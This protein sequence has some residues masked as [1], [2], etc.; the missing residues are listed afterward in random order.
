MSQD[1]KLISRMVRRVKNVVRPWIRGNPNYFLRKASG[2]IH[3]GAN[4]GQ[5]RNLYGKHN[6]DVI[7][8]E[9]IPDVYMSLKQNLEGFPRQHAFQRLITDRDDAE[10]TFHISNNDGKSSSIFD[11]DLHKEIWPTVSFQESIRLKGMT[12]ASFAQK[13][14]IDMNR[15]DA[16]VLD[17]QGS[18]LLVLKGASTLFTYFKYIK[19]EAADFESYAGCCKVEDIDSLLKQ[20]GYVKRRQDKFASKAGVGSYYDVLYK[21][22]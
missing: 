21:Q 11:L 12:L 20:F 5:E 9:P 22:T 18:E 4:S 6:L 1:S 3:V 17:T 13:E 16:L 14:G 2:V 10:Y 7:W 8:I 19:T 15:Y